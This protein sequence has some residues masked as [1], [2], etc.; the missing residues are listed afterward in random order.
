[1]RLQSI[2]IVA[3]VMFAVLLAACE[4]PVD[5]NTQSAVVAQPQQT[6]KWKMVTTWPKNFPGLGS[7]ANRYA[8]LVTE[9][10]GGRIEVKV[11]GAKELVGAL[12][13]FDAVSRGTAELG[14]GGAYYWKGKAAAAQFFSSVPFGMT[15]QEMN[16]WLYQGG[17]LELWQEVYEPFG[18]VPLAVGNSGTQM[19]GWFNKEIN[20]IADLKGLK[21]RL[22]GL[23]G[24]V[25]RRA[26]GVPVL[27]PGGEIFPSLQ[28]GV[29]DATEWVGPYNDLA[30]GLHKAAKY[31]YY[32]GWHEPGT[33]MELI[34]NKE[35]LQSLPADLQSIVTNAAK[36]ANLEMLADF[37]ARNNQALKTLVEEHGVELRKFP[38]EVIRRLRE[39]SAAVVAEAGANDP[40]STKVYASF[41]AFNKQVSEWTR[42]SEQAYLEARTM[43]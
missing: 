30:F 5:N 9:M 15:A 34:V 39:L 37:S 3:M 2:K 11:Y 8:E 35:A 17:G 31:Y 40:M 38:D 16:G 28:T 12:E 7:G 1:M 33:T 4:E 25:L 29:I 19:G 24:E 20:T 26:G 27:L 14:H 41:K 23:G 6:I 22:P 42:I 36:V 10:S 43:E 21:M 13:V 32:P 18:L